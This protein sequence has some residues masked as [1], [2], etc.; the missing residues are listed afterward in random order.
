MTCTDCILHKTVK[1]NCL[2]GEG[3]L[4]SGI[5]IVGDFPRFLED[6]KGKPFIGDA[7]KLLDHCLTKVGI[8]RRSIYVTNAVKCKS[9]TK[10]NK[11]TGAQITAC[12]KHIVKEI[13]DLKPK[14]VVLLGNPAV[15]SVLK[16][17]SKIDKIR[18]LIQESEEFPGI[19]FIPTYH[20]A[21]ILTHWVD[22][23][24]LLK[25]LKRAVKASKFNDYL[26][27]CAK[28]N[29]R[30]SYNS[31]LTLAGVE[32]LMEYLKTSSDFVSYD[33]ETTGLDVRNDTII[34][35]QFSNRVG[36]GW[37]VPLYGFKCREVWSEENKVKVIALLKDF[38]GGA[39]PKVAH[40]SMFDR[41]I[42]RCN[43]GIEVN[44]TELD[45]QYLH[46]QIQEE[47][48]KSL[49]YLTNKYTE[50]SPFK[51]LK[52]RFPE[53]KQGYQ[54]VP[55]DA[56]WLYGAQ[57]ADA[58]YRVAKILKDAALKEGRLFE[59]H[60][61]I[62]IPLSEVIMSISLGG[63]QLG[64][65]A[66]DEMQDTH[67]IE[68]EELVN[69]MIGIV[70]RKFNPNSPKQLVE[71]LFTEFKLPSI[72]KTKTGSKSTDKEVLAFLEGKHPIIEFLIEYKSL[73]KERSDYLKGSD[74][75]TGILKHADENM[76]VHPDWR[77]DGTVTGR[78]A[79]R[80]P[81]IHNIKKNMRS[82]ISVLD[83]MYL[84]GAD[85][86]QLEVRIAAVLSGDKKLNSYFEEGL[87]IH[88][89]VAAD[90]LGKEEKEI[91]D[92]ERKNAKGVV[93]GANYLRGAKSISDEY[94]MTVEVAQAYLD[95]Y[96]ESFKG[97]KKW[98]DE[99]VAEMKKMRFIE[100]VWGRRRRLGNLG[101]LTDAFI[102]TFYGDRV[103]ETM[104]IQREES[105]RQG[106]NAIIQSAGGD[107]CNSVFIRLHKRYQGMRTNIII[108]H[109]DAIYCESPED[110][111]VLASKILI[112]EMETPVPELS[113]KVFPVDFSAG[114]FWG[115]E[116]ETEKI[117]ERMKIE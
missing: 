45:T 102:R 97:F 2:K 12:R 114:R 50:M 82:I 67:N 90:I 84:M 29:S 44:N 1:T 52:D 74:G 98:R 24:I 23:P 103:R 79:C 106:F 20:P 18:S 3:S 93:F 59:L 96:F 28:L 5:M 113:N 81:A 10:D 57:D 32:S 17:S 91:T 34:S 99:K 13:K 109:H 86:K 68:I 70:G 33:T 117:L 61:K 48:H 22:L 66:L 31:V 78:L 69:K 75:K 89:M 87:D 19:V 112:E 53:A 47:E 39:T 55:E 51:D 21:Y 11:V 26:G 15:Q 42:L 83:G 115:D 104:A 46:H 65:A 71:I 108:S 36:Y 25:D 92:E 95:G 116:S 7:G 41:S 60:Q 94:G 56:L 100:T 105:V 63:I 101:A 14:V 49:E 73:A 6:L 80:K 43:L 76:K 85:W 35:I 58:T 40:N 54:N 37:T 107:L 8:A 77:V 62:V 111:I 72:K 64:V 4:S 38:L 110:E 27:Y 88:R 9:N 16:R 30:C